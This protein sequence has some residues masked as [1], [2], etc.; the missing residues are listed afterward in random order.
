MR[1]L[2]ILVAI[3]A[4]AHCAR[5]ATLAVA[6]VTDTSAGSQVDVP[7]ILTVSS[8]EDVAGIQLDILFD[9]DA[10]GAPA[11]EAGQAALDAGKGVSSSLVS[12]DRLRLVI[13]GIN[14]N[15]MDSGTVATVVFTIPAATPD[16]TQ[17]LTV[18]NGLLADPYG[19]QV[20]VTTVSGSIVIGSDPGN[21]SDTPGCH[22]SHSDD[23]VDGIAWLCTVGVILLAMYS[24]RAAFANIPAPRLRNNK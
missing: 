7:V 19:N 22:A 4:A 14:Q 11:V 20:A 2:V 17:P 1:P 9:A 3:V 15:T 16:G 18:D 23:R 13:A 8:S 6:N 12:E 5:A 10:L 21:G 24:K